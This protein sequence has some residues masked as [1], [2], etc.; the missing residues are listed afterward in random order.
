M[1]RYRWGTRD[2]GVI[3]VCLTPDTDAV[4]IVLEKKLIV[5]TEK[6]PGF[7]STIDRWEPLC[8]S[9]SFTFG[10][11]PGWLLAMVW[12]ESAGN[13]RA[14]RQE[15]DADGKPRIVKGRLLTGIG[16]LQITHPD[17]KRGLSDEALYDP[18]TNLL[19]GARYI[20]D[21]MMQHGRDFAKISAAFNAGGVY[22]SDRN[23]WN[24]KQTDGHVTAE[25][26]A[27]NFYLL[28]SQRK[29]AELAAAYQFTELELLGDDF[30]RI[31]LIDE[32]DEEPVTK[33]D[34]PKPS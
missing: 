16:L 12:R 22:P 28:Q 8:K 14:F 33:N 34:L 17:L 21:L 25:V 3:M 18:E 2:D 19:C 10:I 30:G 23:P 31:T 5:G 1:N 27:L 24:L 6:V 26:S 11:P 32:D 15:R 29:A 4:A 9:V 20:A 13:P 7:Q